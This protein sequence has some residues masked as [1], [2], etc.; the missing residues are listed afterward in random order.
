MHF[1]YV[2]KLGTGVIVKIMLDESLRG[3]WLSQIDSAD[4]VR[5]SAT[6]FHEDCTIMWYHITFQTRLGTVTEPS[7]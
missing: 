5:S 3:S 1:A 4:V 2:H 7:A 6:Q